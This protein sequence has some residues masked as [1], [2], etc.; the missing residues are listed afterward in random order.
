MSPRAQTDGAARS[1]GEL[2]MTETEV[3]SQRT[4]FESARERRPL[5]AN[6]H[7]ADDHGDRA[8]PVQVQHGK[9]FTS[10]AGSSK[11][12]VSSLMMLLLF[13]TVTMPFAPP[14]NGAS[15]RAA[16]QTSDGIERGDV[17][18]SPA[19]S[20]LPAERTRRAA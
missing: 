12:P 14:P 1:R 11:L 17:P 13:R 9:L 6:S 15:A 4:S 20:I 19:P 7:V 8:A 18:I 3:V 5:D 2:A 16:M 10:C